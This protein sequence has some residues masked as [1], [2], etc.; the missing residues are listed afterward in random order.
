MTTLEQKM[1]EVIQSRL[2]DYMDYTDFCVFLSYFK[3]G[4][5]LNYPKK[6]LRSIYGPRTYYYFKKVYRFTKTMLAM[7]ALRTLTC[8]D[9][10]KQDCIIDFINYKNLGN[11]SFL[12]LCYGEYKVKI[13]LDEKIYNR[14]LN[15]DEVDINGIS[16]IVEKEF[17]K[18]IAKQ[19]V[20][21]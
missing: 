7:K 13:V 12:K 20:W 16:Y 19:N 11:K 9:E 6:D 18:F 2:D 4:I 15:V 1:L 8:S 5:K 3:D 10:T 17:K 14:F 21:L